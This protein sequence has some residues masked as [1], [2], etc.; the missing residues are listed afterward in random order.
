[1]H[2]KDIPFVGPTMCEL[3][4]EVGPESVENYYLELQNDSEVDT[5]LVGKLRASA[6]RWD[7]PQSKQPPFAQAAVTVA[8]PL[9]GCTPSQA[10]LGQLDPS[11]PSESDDLICSAH[12]AGE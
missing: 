6:T 11:K 12:R 3:S 2:S 1:M 8:R 7:R 10:C 9:G 5:I 4:N